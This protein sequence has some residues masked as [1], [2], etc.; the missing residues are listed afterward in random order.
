MTLTTDE[1]QK[2][3]AHQSTQHAMLIAWGRFAR[4]LDLTKR[5]RTAVKLRRH[6]D[7][8]PGGDLVLEFG[9]SSL[10]GYEYLQDLSLGARPLTKD[11]AV[12]D[13]WDIQF[14]HYSVLSRFLYALNETNVA[15]I[16]ATLASILQPYI[17]QAVQQELCRQEKLTLCADLTGRPVSAY[18]VTYPPDAVFG[19][20]ANQLRK[21]HQALLVTIKG[22]Q[23]R[24]H[25][26][27][28]HYPG[29]VASNR[30]LRQSVEAAEKRLGYRPRRRTELVDQRIACI[31]A[32]IAK[33][34]CRVE[35]QQAIMHQQL[36]RQVRLDAQMQ[37]LEKE[38]VELEAHYA[39]KVVRPHSKLAKARRRKASWERQRASAFK[40][41]TRAQRLLQRYKQRLEGLVAE[42]DALLS[43][44]AQLNA[45]NQ[46]NPNPVQ[47]R[48]L[49]DGGFGSAENVTYLI[50]MGYD[51]YTIANGRMTQSIRTEIPED[52]EWT[53][54]G[55]RTQA[56]DL[57]RDQ[58]RQCPYP[59]RLTLLRWKKGETLCYST[60][61]SFSDT[62]SLPLEEL[63]PTYHQ[64]QDVEAGIRQGKGTFSYTK[65]HVR[66]PAGIRLLGQ[67]A[68]F[69]WPNFVHWAAE[70]LHDQVAE[71]TDPLASLLHH[72]GTQV[73]VAANTPATVL[74]NPTGQMLEFS[75][76]GPYPGLCIC[77]DRSFAYQLP[78]P[79]FQ[80][81]QPQWPVSSDSVKE[82][83]SV[84]LAEQ[85]ALPLA[86]LRAS[87]LG[88]RLPEK[89]PKNRVFG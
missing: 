79:L 7:A 69:F 68:L 37:G 62:E 67:F 39:N 70:W 44:L 81:G 88:S 42:R 60:L 12:A 17:D 21:G 34:T 84:L 6:K 51:L 9:L 29:N 33:Q 75:S 50:E 72:V 56:L 36:K 5:V 35:T 41:E 87:Q 86:G 77:L 53:Q 2:D 49:L 58:L 64:R 82:Q 85:N 25:L 48:W 31:E 19:Y 57:A 54:V 3:T 32:E 11:Q 47:M 23:H 43:W 1:T 59:V 71:D 24:V 78:M 40:Q 46:A 16:E 18:S 27:A 55:V 63:F 20:M 10:A 22:R 13:A 45:D 80:A 74:T 26:A 83:L 73:R 66:S 8:V 28:F 76:D 38:L 89:V 14:R 61:V 4:Y 15:E 65:L 52:A 30:C